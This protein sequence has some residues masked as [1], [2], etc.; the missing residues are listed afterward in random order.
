MAAVG[1][2]IL[3]IFITGV[4]TGIV[5]LVSVASRR[6]DKRWTRQRSRLSREAPDRTTLA[7]RY[8]TSLYVRRP[9]DEVAPELLD[10]HRAEIVGQ[11]HLRPS[12][13]T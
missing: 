3:I 12:S 11:P 1:L 6:E 13:L 5:A 2:A 7:A 8:L 10:D 4:I 9:G